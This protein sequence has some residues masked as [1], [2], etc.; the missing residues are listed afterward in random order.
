MTLLL[1]FWIQPLH[2][3]VNEYCSRFSLSWH[4]GEISWHSRETLPWL[5]LC[6]HRPSLR[7]ACALHPFDGSRSS[8]QVPDQE[9]ADFRPQNVQERSLW[10][11]NDGGVHSQRLR[12]ATSCTAAASPERILSI[13]VSIQRAAALKAFVLTKRVKSCPLFLYISFYICTWC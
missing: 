5:G 8:D 10:D 7:G 2:Y 3:P 12:N 1:F 6:H 9:I 4:L 13:C 11:R